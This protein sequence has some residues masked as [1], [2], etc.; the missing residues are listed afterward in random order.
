MAMTAT[1]TRKRPQLI[2]GLGNPGLQYQ[3]TRH[4][5]GFLVVDLLAARHG[6]RWREERQAAVGRWGDVTLLKP[7]TFMN[8]SG[9]AIQAYTTKL[10]VPPAELLVVHDDLDLPLGRLRLRVGGSAGGQRGVQDTIARL[11]SNFVRLKVGISRPPAGWKVENWVLSRFREEEKALLDE[12][13]TH[14]ADAVEVLLA[15]GLETAMGRFNGLDLRPQAVD[16][17]QGP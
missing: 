15:D 13:I 14:A 11:G 6:V 4:N 12:V 10:G 17:P 7:L 8:L 2:V 5:A 3:N 16:A 1:A 9:S